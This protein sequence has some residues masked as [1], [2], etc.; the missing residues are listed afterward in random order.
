MR[1]RLIQKF[2]VFISRLNEAE[3]GAVVGGGWDPDFHEAVPVDDGTQLGE[4]STKYHDEIELTCQI[5][6]KEWGNVELMRNGRQIKADIILTLHVP[7]LAKKGMINSKGQLVLRE[8]DRVNRINDLKGNLEVEFENPPG[9][10]VKGSERAGHGLAAFRTPKT[11]LFYLYC[12]YDEKGK[13]A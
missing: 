12:S 3:T 5:D 1:G 13:T 4:D 10:F 7:E 11:N 8:G 6:R 2:K 9:M